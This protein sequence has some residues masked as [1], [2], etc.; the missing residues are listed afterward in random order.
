MK[1]K[2]LI[3]ICSIVVFI[4]IICIIFFIGR[5]NNKPIEKPKFNK[6]F[7]YLG[8]NLIEE[9][10]NPAII[11]SY[12]EYR[13][14]T[15]SDKINEEDF[16]NNNYVLIPINYDECSEEY[17]VPTDYEITDTKIIVKFSYTAKCG[18]CAPQYRYYLLKVDKEVV[19]QEVKVEYKALNNPGCDPNVSYK[20]LIYIYPEED[21][22]VSVTLGNSKLLTTTYPKYD[23]GWNVLAK[24]DGT[25]IDNKGRSY[26]GLY[27]EG[28]NYIDND[29]KDGFVVKGTDSI[30]FLEEKLSILGLNER[31]ANEFIMYWLPKLENNK[32]NLIRFLS[33]EEIDEQ[34]SL[35]I[36]PTPDTIIRIFMIYK[37]LNK[38]ESIKEQQLTKVERHG[39]SVIEWGG[40]LVK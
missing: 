27:W 7:T 3:I 28:N 25:L 23:N 38:K 4:I 26:Y 2:R 11:K 17:L 37:P 39:Y 6:S 5:L 8:E 33:K 30:K 12:K 1:K 29:Y 35:N 19:D 22:R 13:I 20:P 9:V 14:I 36:T 32:Y 34:M 31:E 10:T 21:T 18:L 24:A 40:S 16:S 15:D